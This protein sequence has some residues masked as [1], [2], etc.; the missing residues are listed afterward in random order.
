MWGFNVTHV[1]ENSLSQARVSGRL[2]TSGFLQAGCPAGINKPQPPQQLR[3]ITS[4][5]KSCSPSRCPG[6]HEGFSLNDDMHGKHST[7]VQC[8]LTAYSTTDSG[9]PPS[10]TQHFT[11]ISSDSK[12][13]DCSASTFYQVKSTSKL[14]CGHLGP[15]EVQGG[16]WGCGS[17][18]TPVTK[19]STH[20]IHDTP[21]TRRPQAASSQRKFHL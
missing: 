9:R 2:L 14:T 17:T 20:I 10:P 18:H 8:Q 3:E 13:R 15:L 6:I 5:R 11:E 21:G 12:H 4:Q 16:G 19:R 7:S 1:A